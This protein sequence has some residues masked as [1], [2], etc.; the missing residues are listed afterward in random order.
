[1]RERG[2]DTPALK[3]EAKGGGGGAAAAAGGGGGGGGGSVEDEGLAIAMCCGC[4]AACSKAAAGMTEA[5]RGADAARKV[6]RVMN[7]AEDY[8]DDIHV[9]DYDDDDDDDNDDDDNGS[10]SDDDDALLDCSPAV[11]L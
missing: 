5:G 3:V 11:S 8:D 1:M 6:D 2:D 4:Y 9:D 7:D 10:G